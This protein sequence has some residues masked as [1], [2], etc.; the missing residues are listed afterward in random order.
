MYINDLLT[1]ERRRLDEVF[2]QHQGET[3]FRRYDRRV[4]HDV[5]H[6]DVVDLLCAIES[7]YWT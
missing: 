6:D 7:A 1:A 5:Y 4:F 2:F 3:V